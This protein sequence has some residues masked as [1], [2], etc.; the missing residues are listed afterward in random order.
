MFQKWHLCQILQQILFFSHA[1]KMHLLFL[2]FR[3][4][5]T[6]RL[7]RKQQAIANGTS[8]SEE[9]DSDNDME[10]EGGF[11]VPF[12]IWNKLYR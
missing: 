10:F 8:D 2:F 4:H 11:K 9:T 7:K 12:R 3:E 5:K 1:V 6:E